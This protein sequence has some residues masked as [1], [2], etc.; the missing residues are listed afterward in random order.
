MATPTIPP[1]AAI[2]ALPDGAVIVAGPGCG[3][4]TTLLRA[5]GD[6]AD[7][8][9]GWELSSALLLGDLGF[10]AAVQE[11]RLRYR[12]WHVVAAT[13]DLVVDGHAEFVPLRGSDLP[14]MLAAAPP[15]AVL[16][17]VSPPDAAGEVSL[18]TSV[19][20]TRAAIEAGRMVIGEIDPGMPRTHGASRVPVDR[21]TAFIESD[22]AT[23]EYPTAEPDATT[24]R[25]A[26][27]VMGLIP[28]DPVLQLGIGGVPEALT[29]SVIDADL[30]HVR[31]L[32]LGTDRMVDLFEAGVLRAG[33]VVPEPAVS[34]VEL[35]GTR[36]MLDFVHDNPA[37]GVYPVDV[38]GDP[39][40]LMLLPR[41]VSVITA[42]EVDLWGQVNLE[43]VSGRQITGLGGSIDF[44]ESA[45]LSPGGVR[46][47][48]LQSTARGMSRIVPRLASGTPVTLGRHAVDHIVTEYGVASLG[49]L[50]LRERA[51]ALIAVAAPE[52]RDA[53]AASLQR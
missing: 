19:S 5:L 31:L 46:I 10:I 16:V 3:T 36:R 39:R 28:R 24:R 27:H 7:S 41:L 42:L 4:P 51:E 40:R 6:A 53:L 45:R 52:H 47:V 15:D 30:G 29:S 44:H 14:G 26:D 20:Y 12:T 50:S 43:Q 17:R 8:A 18:G 22:D 2:D 23:P 48:A 34:A 21:F 37:V 1:G 32:G 35:M 25:I 33:D 13:R 38:A 11:G 49:G 9:R